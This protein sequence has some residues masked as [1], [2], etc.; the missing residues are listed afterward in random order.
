MTLV[1]SQALRYIRWRNKLVTETNELRMKRQKQYFYAFINRTIEATRAD[2]TLPLGLYNN[3]KPYMTTDITPS[4][5]TY[6]TS[7]VLEYGVSGDAISTVK[8]KSSDGANGLVEF[9][10]DDVSLYEMILNTFYNKVS[11]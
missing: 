7:K 3:A 10:A 9:H 11:K 4:K 1:G 2:L 6:L 8:G 5:V